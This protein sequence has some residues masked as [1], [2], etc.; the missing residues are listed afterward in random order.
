[1][2]VRQSL[3]GYLRKRQSEA[4]EVI[5]LF[6]VVVA[7]TL[8][9]QIAEEMKRFHAD[10]SSADPAFQQRP[11]ILKAVGVHLAVHVLNRVVNDLMGVLSGQPFIRQQSIGVESRASF[12][13]FLYFRLNGMA[14]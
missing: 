3:S 6:P 7:K 10:I 4:V 8:L 12:D 2:F 1:M 14:L 11:K 9:I 5:H 13:V